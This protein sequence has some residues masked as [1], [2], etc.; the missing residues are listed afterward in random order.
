MID[1]IKIQEVN[2]TDHA[3]KYKVYLMASIRVSGDINYLN[4][5]TERLCFRF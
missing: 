5:Y 4:S 1:L 3:T 2:G